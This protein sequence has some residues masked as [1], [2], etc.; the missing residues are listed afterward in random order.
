M[1]RIDN[2]LENAVSE[3]CSELFN[4]TP[5]AKQVSVQ[6]TRPE[7]EGERTVVVFP[8]TRFSKKSPEDTGTALGEY[9]S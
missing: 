5:D 7:F 8:F 2:I 6:L 1:L 9:H 3:G 4:A